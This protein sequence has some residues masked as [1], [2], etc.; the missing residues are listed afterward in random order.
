[1][2]E[3]SSSHDV[4]SKK[5]NIGNS[6]GFQGLGLSDEVYRGIVKMGFRVSKE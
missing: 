4:K 1:M 5:K 6:G 3:Q 2:A